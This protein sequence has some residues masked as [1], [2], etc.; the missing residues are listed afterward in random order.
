MPFPLGNM[1]VFRSER[2]QVC[3]LLS[4]VQGQEERE[5]ISKG[6]KLWMVNI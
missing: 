4:R 2:G 6:V 1:P 5:M 3:N